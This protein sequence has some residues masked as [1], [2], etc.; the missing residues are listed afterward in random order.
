VRRV[1]WAV[2]VTI[3]DLGSIGKLVA[4]V[5]TIITLIYL[6]TQIRQNTHS[7]ATSIYDSAMS[8][9][10]EH[11]RWVIGNEKLSSILYR[12]FMDSDDLDEEE[13]FRLNFVHRCYANHVY[14]LF[15]L[16]ENGAFPEREWHNVAIEAAQ[17]FGIPGVSEFKENNRYFG[18]LW[19]ELDRFE[20]QSFSNFQAPKS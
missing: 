17:V 7:V 12:G 6:A 9:F 8:G 2:E 14:K 11:N 10:N 4:A 3:Q 19:K 15:R 18:D 1:R 5:A 13:R 16:Y 20:V